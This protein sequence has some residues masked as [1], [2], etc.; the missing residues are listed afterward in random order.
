MTTYDYDIRDDVALLKNDKFRRLLQSRLA[1][2]TAQNAMIYALLILL[3]EQSGSSVHSTLLIVALTIP[4]IL[5]GIPG[6]AVADL[7]PRR[8]TLTLGYLGRAGVAAALF[9]Y[10]GDLVYLYLVVLAHSAIGQ[11][12]GPAESA[13][14][15]AI[16]RKDQ[17]STAN[18]LMML[19]LMF[20]QIAGL[21]V[22]APILIKLISPE[23]VFI[24]AACLYLVA[25]YIVGW[26]ASDFTRS[27]D[28]KPPSIGFVD[29]MTQGFRILRTN[30]H[31]YLAIVYLT[32]G[33]A[34]SKVLII[35]MPKY[36]RDVLDI[37]PEDTVFV[38]APAA[39]GA[40]VGLLIVPLAIKLFGAWRVAAGAFFI[41]V[42][43]LVGLG[44]VVYVR[45]FITNNF[46][47]GFSFVEDN[48]SL[49]TVVTVTMLLAIPLG[50]SF[51][52]LNVAT[53]VVMNEQAPQEAQGRI[54]AMQMALGDTLS[55]LPLL[56]VGIVADVVGVRAT[57]LASAIAALAAAGYLTFSKRFGPIE[58]EE[59][60]SQPAAPVT[61]P[62]L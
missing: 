6:G 33:L 19:S 34:L 41:F 22:L 27:Q 17:L 40:G 53:R 31:A 52:V 13:T 36:T 7:L 30:R 5:L 44:L 23:S 55:L 51:T 47:I 59:A 35:L 60:P 42:L 38:A 15:P 14:V 56:L 32:T 12:F 4:S 45:T 11:F 37:A 54:F 2:Q 61:E 24:V 26:L 25:T 62:G 1:G 28:E 49:A 43:G 21:V 18:S 3:V 57:L 50:L 48:F 10:S 8:F 39:I 58:E 16:V 20:A 9:Y 46:D 29:A